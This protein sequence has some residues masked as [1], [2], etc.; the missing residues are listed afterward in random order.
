MRVRE[1]GRRG[2]SPGCRSWPP[3][4]PR[5]NGAPGDSAQET[6]PS[7]PDINTGDSSLCSPVFSCYPDVPGGKARLCQGCPGMRLPVLEGCPPGD[8]PDCGGLQSGRRG[9]QEGLWRG[10][11]R[12][13]LAGPPAPRRRRAETRA[14]D[15]RGALVRP[16]VQPHRRPGGAEGRES[17]GASTGELTHRTVPCVPPLCSYFSA[18]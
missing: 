8:C 18:L 11:A 10:V 16:P 7:P 6:R 5:S 2:S 4:L 12:C 1:C 15:D 13:S 14:R 3:T 17:Q 9:R